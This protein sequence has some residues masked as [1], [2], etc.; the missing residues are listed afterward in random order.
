MVSI[1]SVPLYLLIGCFRGFP[2]RVVLPLILFTTWANLFCAL[3]LPILLGL[4]NTMTLLSIVQP[5]FG[6]A[7]LVMLRYSGGNREWLHPASDFNPVIFRWKRLVGFVAAN[8]FLIIPLLG[9]YLACSLS[10]TISHLSQGFLHLSAKGISAEART[11]LY[12][13]THI[14]LLP[15][16][17]IAQPSFYR[18][19]LAS[20]SRE[21]T[22]VIP[23]GVS[24]RNNLLKGPL[25][26]RK[27][28]SHMGLEAQNNSDIVAG[29]NVERCDVDISDF[30]PGT[31]D[32]LRTSISILESWTSG[33]RLMA[34][35][36]SISTQDPEL[37]LL[38]EDL[39]ERR[40]QRV[41]DCIAEQMRTYGHIV[42][43]WGAAHMPGIERALLDRGST[44]VERRRI[45]VW[46]WSSQE[47]NSPNKADP[48][49]GT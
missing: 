19:L 47:H 9:I 24:D 39:L 38:L 21:D 42:I 18:L 35:Q 44:I 25:D 3:P 32:W 8:A 1:M 14:H 13:G 15:T 40:N 5:I 29:R 26:Y 22:L 43:P 37:D 12:D 27:L 33:D 49:D 4:H 28:A 41:V 31:I 6:I 36:K 16:V 17:H 23:E 7:M 46:G 34:L 10:F 11:Y 48:D 45:Q 20:L 30:S 2:K